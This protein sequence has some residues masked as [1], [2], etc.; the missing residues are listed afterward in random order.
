MRPATF[1]MPVRNPGEGEK[2]RSHL[3]TGPDSFLPQGLGRL[4]SRGRLSTRG[5]G[6]AV[7]VRD[8]LVLVFCI[9]FYLK[10]KVF[11]EEGD[12]WGLERWE[13]SAEEVF[14]SSFLRLFR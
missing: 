1:N 7:R 11:E 8:T 10:C 12:R 2:I 5:G 3:S 13:A 14:C 9:I 6:V 4:R